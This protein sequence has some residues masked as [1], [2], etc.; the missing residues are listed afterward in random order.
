MAIYLGN[1]LLTGPSGGGGD[2]SLSAD[3][4][5]TGAN[6]FTGSIIT[7]SGTTLTGISDEET[8]TWT[9]VFT[10]G[11]T[12]GT[13]TAIYSK[14][15]KNVVLKCTV[16]IAASTSTAEFTLATTSLPFEPAGLLDSGSGTYY[17]SLL[18]QPNPSFTITSGVVTTSAL[19]SY[20]INGSAPL[21]GTELLGYLG[22]TIT[23]Q[24]SD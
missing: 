15:G 7:D 10:A 9:P 20:F 13:P 24:T 17:T 6:T 14:S 1:T 23:Y 4:T 22:F 18:P 21:T 3:Q 19:L 11:G 12:Q 16:S 8:G 2:A 5:F